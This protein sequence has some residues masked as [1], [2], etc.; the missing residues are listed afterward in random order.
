M[1]RILWTGW[2]LLS[3]VFA[4]G[5]HV[6]AGMILLSIIFMFGGGFPAVQSFLGAHPFW[7]LYGAIC[8]AIYKSANGFSGRVEA[9]LNQMV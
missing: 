8:L 1:K 2:V 6:G 7:L 5:L 4:I 3:V 9:R